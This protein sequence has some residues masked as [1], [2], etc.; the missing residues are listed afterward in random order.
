[1]RT[2]DRTQH[3]VADLQKTVL[4]LLS[5]RPLSL[6]EVLDRLSEQRASRAAVSKA[7]T[8]LIRQGDVDLTPDRQLMLSV[9]HPGIEH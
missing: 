2:L 6:G 5:E 4:R 8:G 9:E 1:M 3:E 7:I